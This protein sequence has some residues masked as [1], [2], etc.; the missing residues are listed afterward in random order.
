MGITV[1]VGKDQFKN[2]STLYWVSFEEMLRK[3]PE[4]PLIK[5]KFHSHISGN[6]L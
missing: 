3:S 2:H 6:V 4:K 1:S 5:I